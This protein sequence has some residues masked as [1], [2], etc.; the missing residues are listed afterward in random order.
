MARVRRPLPATDQ[1][2]IAEQQ[3]GLALEPAERN[4]L[5]EREDLALEGGEVGELAA[6]R[7]AECFY[8]GSPLTGGGSPAPGPRLGRA[9][10]P[11]G[12]RGLSRPTPRLQQ[13]A[14][15]P[16]PGRRAGQQMRPRGVRIRTRISSRDI[17]RVR[18]WGGSRPSPGLGP[19]AAPLPSRRI[20]RGQLRASLPAAASR[21]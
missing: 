1:R 7:R 16:V 5:D 8:A 15:A 2:D 12:S 17:A 21:P 4:A 18:G 10:S 14:P 13:P 19:P 11:R 3:T 6:L 20:P 9:C